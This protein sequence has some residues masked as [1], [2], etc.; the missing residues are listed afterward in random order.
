[1][2]TRLVRYSCVL[3]LLLCV[4]SPLLLS[5]TNTTALSGIVTDATGA[6]LPNANV[7]IANGATGATQTTQSKAKG[8]FL[9]RT[10]SARQLSRE[11]ERAGILRTG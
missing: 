10:D 9:F 7:T 3:M 5:Q 2:M 11:G 4:S 1:M 8:E 6:S